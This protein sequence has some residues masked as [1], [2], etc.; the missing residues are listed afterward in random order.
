MKTYYSVKDLCA[1]HKELLEACKKAEQELTIDD[2]NKFGTVGETVK[3][4]RRT[5]ANAEGKEI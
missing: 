5:I 2:I 3:L 1:S 4:L